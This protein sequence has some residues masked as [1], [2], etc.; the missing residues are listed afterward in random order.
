MI[1]WVTLRKQLVASF[2]EDTVQQVLLGL[3]EEQARGV[4]VLDPLHW[5]R[6]AASR[7]RV[8]HS[9]RE[10]VEREGKDTLSALGIPLDNRS[11]TEQARER[12]RRERRRKE[13]A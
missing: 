12:K 13:A 7:R 4:I 3:L 11:G 10:Q 8:D 1:D 5:C 6:K 9:R 2:D